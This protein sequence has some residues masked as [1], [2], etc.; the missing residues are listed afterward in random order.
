MINLNFDILFNGSFDIHFS[1]ILKEIIMKSDSKM[2][3]NFH[4]LESE[5]NKKF[6]LQE[7]RIKKLEEMV[8]CLV[9]MEYYMS[10][11]SSSNNFYR[12]KLNSLEFSI[13]SSSNENMNMCNK[14]EYFYQLNKLT[15]GGAYSYS[16]IC[17]KNKTLKILII[18]AGTLTNLNGLNNLPSLE[19]LEIRTNG[20][21][22]A[23][24]IIPY[25]HKNIKK[26]TYFGGYGT[27]TKEKLIPYCAKNNIELLYT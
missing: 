15:I 21:N 19:E 27:S 26:I 25:L 9:N 12:E 8:E 3:L 10:I 4:K 14:I 7:Q 16:D 23:D 6:E 17:F 18:Q 20:L 24:T 2:T 11:N 13:L 1:F 22:N 5:Y